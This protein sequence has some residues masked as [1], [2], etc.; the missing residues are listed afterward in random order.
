M[1]APEEGDIVLYDIEFMR[2]GQKF[3]ADIKEDGAI[4]EEDAA[5]PA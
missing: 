1:R 3:E 5:E 4:L 2:Q